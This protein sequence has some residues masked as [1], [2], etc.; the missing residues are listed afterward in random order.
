M[1]SDDSPDKT[2]SS[3]S[4]SVSASSLPQSEQKLDA[5]LAKVPEPQRELIKH[6]I[7]EVFRDS[8]TAIIQGAS[9]PRIESETAKIITESLD[10]D[11]ANKFQ[12]LT[13]KQKDEADDSKR[14]HEFAILRHTDRKKM[15]WPCLMTVL[16]VAVGCIVAGIWL[17]ATGHEM[18]GSNLLT[19]I[20]TALLA[21]LGGLGTARFFE[22]E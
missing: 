17:A 18:L 21:F 7:H 14:R 19:G 20:I 13:Q 2:P 5:V 10:K 12:Y 1:T 22:E 8:F 6:T 15:I 11:N 16:I 4:D 9:G 3:P